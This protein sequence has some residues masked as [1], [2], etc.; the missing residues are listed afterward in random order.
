M[1]E[2]RKDKSLV[3]SLSCPVGEDS[4]RSREKIALSPTPPGA[5]FLITHD[6]CKYRRVHSTIKSPS[7]HTIFTQVEAAATIKFKSAKLQL[8]FKGGYNFASHFFMSGYS[9][10]AAT[11]DIHLLFKHIQ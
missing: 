3:F 6:H 4:H 2:S 8:L 11:N 1:K 10:G 9:S 5:S 7:K